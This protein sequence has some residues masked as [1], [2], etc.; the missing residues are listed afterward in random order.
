MR[1]RDEDGIVPKHSKV[2][3][4]PDADTS[5]LGQAGAK[6]LSLHVDAHLP[7]ECLIQVLVPPHSS[8]SH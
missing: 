3:A 5:F 1:L 6:R 8:P 4:Q 7:L 2:V